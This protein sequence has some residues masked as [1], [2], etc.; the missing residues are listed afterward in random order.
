[1]RPII[2]ATFATSLP[3]QRDL[4]DASEDCWVD[5]ATE[6]DSERRVRQEA[7]ERKLMAHLRQL[8]LCPNSQIFTF[9]A[10]QIDICQ[11]C[12]VIK[13]PE[14]SPAQAR[15]LKACCRIFGAEFAIKREEARKTALI[16]FPKTNARPTSISD[17][18]AM[19][20][21]VCSGHSVRSTERGATT[22]QLTVST[23]RAAASSLS[24][25]DLSIQTTGASSVGDSSQAHS[26]EGIRYWRRRFQCLAFKRRKR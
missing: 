23:D 9:W 1:M 17:S 26:E 24:R 22:G 13:D 8:V 20:P 25:Q 12:V 6:T 11:A 14:P 4:P 16:R 7:N 3:K 10:D 2:L 21:A 5:N 15:Y 19:S 18:V